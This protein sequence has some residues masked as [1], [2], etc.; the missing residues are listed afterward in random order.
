M[1]HSFYKV[2]M[3]HI[4]ALLGTQHLGVGFGGSDHYR[5]PSAVHAAA[6]PGDGSNVEN[7]LHTCLTNRQLTLTFDFCIAC[8]FLNYISPRVALL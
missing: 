5:F 6:P 1:L 2:K 3:G 8:G 7:K 4:A